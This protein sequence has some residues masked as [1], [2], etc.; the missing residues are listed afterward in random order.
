M[1]SGYMKGKADMGG[2][3][4]MWDWELFG[5]RFSIF[6]FERVK[7]ALKWNRKKG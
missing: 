2:G 5:E 4:S 6:Y 7:R 1:G 3:N